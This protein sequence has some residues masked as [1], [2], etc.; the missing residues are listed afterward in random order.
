MRLRGS[1]FWCISLA[2]TAALAA[3]KG[4]ESGERRIAVGSP[5]PQYSALSLA[6]DSV[7]L[8]G[9]RDKV[10]LLNVWA[11]WCHPCRA[12]I[13]ELQELH[14]KYASRGLDVVGVSI[15]A[16]SD[17]EHISEFMKEFG[18]TYPIWRDPDERVSAQ[19]L[20]LG[21]PTTYLLD[22][23]GIL[24]WRTTGPIRPGDTTL[25]RAIESALAQ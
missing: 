20:V 6:G 10:V 8:A 12:E 1:G 18:M 15:D 14:T 25:V 11:T 13:P 4:G 5:V 3:C 17:K 24:R 7:S 2:L 9:L 19:F 16:E 21:V 22:R 23:K